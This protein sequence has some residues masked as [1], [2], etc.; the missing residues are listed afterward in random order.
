MCAQ[1]PD[2]QESFRSG[3]GTGIPGHGEFHEYPRLQL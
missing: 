3:Y 1:V 2:V